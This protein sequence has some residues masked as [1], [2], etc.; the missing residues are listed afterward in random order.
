M[1]VEVI[2]DQRD[3]LFQEKER[4]LRLLKV[5]DDKVQ[6]DQI[7]GKLTGLSITSSMGVEPKDSIIERL[8]V[9]VAALDSEANEYER[10]HEALRRQLADKER[11][12]ANLRHN[13][14]ID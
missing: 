4:C 12:L 3:A 6:L 8:E 7:V 5:D 9:K 10:S 11:E 1:K 14:H 2:L 13:V